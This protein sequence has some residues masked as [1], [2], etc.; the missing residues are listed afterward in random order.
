MDQFIFFLRT[1]SCRAYLGSVTCLDEQVARRVIEY[2]TCFLDG[3]RF[4]T[5]REVYLHQAGEDFLSLRRVA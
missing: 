2:A 1:T 4:D 3:E 5:V